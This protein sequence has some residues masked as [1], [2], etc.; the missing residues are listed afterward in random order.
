MELQLPKQGLGCSGE[1]LLMLC[2]CES[3]ILPHPSFLL[4]LSTHQSWVPLKQIQSISL[5]LGI[6]QTLLFLL[7][8]CNL[9]LLWLLVPWLTVGAASSKLTERNSQAKWSYRCGA[10]GTVVL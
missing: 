5:S 9:L 7:L 6:T 10:C 1:M 3:L 4:L 8:G 2:C